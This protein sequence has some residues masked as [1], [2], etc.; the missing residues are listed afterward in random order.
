MCRARLVE[1]ERI[2][3]LHQE[4]T[5]AH[6]PEARAHLV[7]EFPL[8]VIEIERQVLVRFDVGAEDFRDHLLVGRPVEHVTLVPV[9]DAQHLLAVGVIASAL[10]PE[11]GRLD[12]RHQHFDRAGAVLLLA[13]DLANLLQHANAERQE[14]IDARGLLP[15]HAGAQHQPVRDDLGL[16]RC[17]AQNRQEITGQAH[18]NPW[19]IRG[20]EVR[21]KADRPQKHKA[22]ANF[23]GIY[24]RLQHLYSVLG[25]LDGAED[26]MRA[27]IRRIAGVAATIAIAPAHNFV[28]RR[29]AVR[30]AKRR[31]V[32]GHLSQRGVGAR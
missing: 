23:S 28:G 14:G 22:R 24:R 18:G 15:H 29:R 1:I 10:A 9:L 31:S 17:L 32:Y 4:F 12:C 13:H 19:E 7:T 6:Q 3:I 2:R 8:D 27:G 30:R 26:N 21:V 25:C 20:D 5:S 11:V 16:F